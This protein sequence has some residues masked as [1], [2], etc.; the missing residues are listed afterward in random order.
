VTGDAWVFPLGHYLGPFFPGR[1]EALECHRV[2]VGGEVARLFTD[3]EF[4][5]WGL[6]HGLPAGPHPAPDSVL[7]R[8]TLTAIASERGETDATGAVSGLLASGV[9]VEAVDPE[10]FARGHRLQPLLSGLGVSPAR[11]DMFHIGLF[12]EQPAAAVDEL[13][14][15]MWQWAPRVGTLWELHEI[16]A[17]TASVLG[18]TVGGV[19]GLLRRLHLLLAN[20]CG[21]LDVTTST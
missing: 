12:G 4:L 15:D 6:A 20:G 16:Q 14:F 17:S 11:P 21:Y 5:V 8:A 10:T 7:T 2:R 9:L 18:D 3:I 19:D 1:G 13:V